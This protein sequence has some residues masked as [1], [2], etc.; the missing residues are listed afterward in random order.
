MRVRVNDVHGVYDLVL[1][2]ADWAGGGEDDP[3]MPERLAGVLECCA[4]DLSIEDHPT[5]RQKPT[6][7]IVVNAYDLVQD[8]STTDNDY[9]A[10]G[11]EDPGAGD[12]LHETELETKE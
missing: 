12:R 4:D 5:G 3:G 11:H 1:W 2:S 10:P 9:R 7:M 6:P 8:P